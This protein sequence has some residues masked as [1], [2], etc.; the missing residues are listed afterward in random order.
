[1]D[2]YYR[3]WWQRIILASFTGLFFFMILHDQRENLIGEACSDTEYLRKVGF[4]KGFECE[5]HFTRYSNELGETQ[6]V[7]SIIFS[8][9]AWTVLAEVAKKE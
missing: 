8:Y 7:G 2:K 3:K 6:L 4:D 9:I 5:K 1:M